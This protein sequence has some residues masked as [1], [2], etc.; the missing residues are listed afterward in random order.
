M[1]FY[2][3]WNDEWHLVGDVSGETVLSVGQRGSGSNGWVDAFNESNLQKVLFV[4]PIDTNTD[5]LFLNTSGIQTIPSDFDFSNSTSITRMFYNSVDLRSVT[6]FD[7]GMASGASE[8][9]MNCSSLESVTGLRLGSAWTL[10]QMFY[11]DSRLGRVSLRNLDNVTRVDELFTGCTSLE[12][13]SLN[14]LGRS[15]SYTTSWRRLDVSMTLLDGDAMDA[16]ADS[17]GECES[18]TYPWIL[19]YKSS[20]VFDTTI[21]TEKGW[22]L[23]PV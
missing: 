23:E 6:G 3:R 14:G 16:L 13:I 12:S 11:G 15:V 21:V 20:V 5:R 2:A 8:V 17:L 22:V 7:F 18:E 4:T 1:A 19:R 10:Y 9:F